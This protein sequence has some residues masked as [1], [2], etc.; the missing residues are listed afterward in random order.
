[1]ARTYNKKNHEYWAVRAQGMQQVPPPQD[2]FKGTP[3]PTIEYGN[4]ALASGGGGS[5]VAFRG[6]QLNNGTVDAGALQ[7]IR[8]LPTPFSTG[9]TGEG[10]NAT[11]VGDAI[12]L[13]VK[14]WFNIPVVRNAVEIAT[15]FSAQPLYVKCKNQR[16]KAFFTEWLNVI[17]S[18]ALVE[19]YFREYYRSG[20]V[21][22]YRFD[23]QMGQSYYGDFQRTFGAKANRVPIRYELINPSFVSVPSGL[24]YPYTYMRM[25]SPW[26]CERLR[27]PLND[28]DKQVFK[29]LP[30]A[31]K[32]QIRKGGTGQGISIP[33]DPKRLRFAFYKKQPYEPMAVPMAWPVL[34]SIEWKLTLTKIDM[35]LARTVDYAVLWV[36]HGESPTKEN[37]GSGINPQNF[38]RLQALLAA[39]S[40]QRV[41]VVDWTSK[42]EWLVP[43][44]Q[45]ILGPE[46]Y[47]VVNAD[48]QEGLQSIFSGDEKFAN[49]QIKAQV[50]IQ[51]LQIGQ[52]GFLEEFLLPE[53]DQICQDMN[54]RDKPE[55][56]FQPINLK[57]EAVLARIYA[58]LA[59]LGVLTGPQTVEAI[60]TQVLPDREEMQEGQNEYK[61]ERDKGLYNPLV[62]GQK[63]DASGGPN[64]R[65]GGTSGIKQ[66]AP[67]SSA[68]IGTSKAAF[69]LKQFAT[70]L[71]ASEKVEGAVE[72]ALRKRYGF[73]GEIAEAQQKVIDSLTTTIIAT[74]SPD[75]WVKAVASLMK[76]PEQIPVEISR[77][78]TEI[79]E[80]CEVD[81]RGAALLRHCRTEP[82][83]E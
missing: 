78:M 38:A 20:N 9:G 61:K 41:M 26:E 79:R 29:S 24:A 58:T 45:E 50:F 52:A 1:M 57:D 69:S 19:S 75:K 43:P 51:R 46:K 32:D 15:E 7:N 3:M 14:A 12:N 16:V 54:F 49:A 47:Q 59:Q 11:S 13:C 66:G 31:V 48:I 36:Q 80:L 73:K 6:R 2:V 18:K 53:V 70:H 8:A 82:P 42:A 5:E 56:G 71:R 28:Q 68:P 63:D 39:P 40:A 77:E 62:G 22:L 17:R 37:G 55:I 10:R 67:R 23:G 34:P 64:G 33:L 21:F 25:L 72:A 35:H 81:E 44:I 65:P 27:S 60:R 74:R 76:K 4:E 83:T 30:D